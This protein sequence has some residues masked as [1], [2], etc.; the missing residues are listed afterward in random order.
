MCPPLCGLCLG[1][2]GMSF[3]HM[4]LV[5]TSSLVF[6]YFDRKE[7]LLQFQG[8]PVGK[9]TSQLATAKAFYLEL[10]WSKCYCQ[11]EK[12]SYLKRFVGVGE[13]RQSLPWDSETLTLLLSLLL[14]VLLLWGLDRK[15]WN[16][17]C[18]QFTL[19]IW[20]NILEPTLL[21]KTDITGVEE[22]RGCTK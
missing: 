21:E 3:C 17:W 5:C 18:C 16:L 4:G 14:T 11:W 7:G 15:S 2:L 19:L 8:L 22:G 1:W 10:T 20:D 12:V 9:V 6:P 13:R